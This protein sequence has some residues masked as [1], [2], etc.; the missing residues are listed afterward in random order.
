MTR[1]GCLRFLAWERER[2]ARTLSARDERTRRFTLRYFNFLL[3]PRLC[4][5]TRSL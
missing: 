1:A 5:G 4:L 2:P 3:V